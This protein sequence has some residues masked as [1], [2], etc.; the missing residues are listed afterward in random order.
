VPNRPFRAA[1]LVVLG[2]LVGTALADGP[3]SR[4]VLD[5][6]A[7]W[8]SH[9]EFGIDRID[10]GALKATGEEVLGERNLRLL[11]RKVKG[12]LKHL[13]PEA[14]AEFPEDWRDC[15]YYH[16][17]ISQFT[18]TDRQA[19]HC[20][21]P[22]APADWMKPDF[23]DSGWPR[24][25]LPFMVGNYY[26]SSL[27]HGDLEMQW[28]GV[29][30]ACYRT[31]FE[32]ADPAVPY[33][34]ELSYRGG[35]RVFVNGAEIA[36][37]DLP[38]GE[39]GPDAH[40]DV[41][42]ADA[43]LRRRREA[44]V[45]P[46]KGSHHDRALSR[47]G[48][49]FAQELP[50]RFEDAFTDLDPKRRA[51]PGQELYWHDGS[52]WPYGGWTRI[53]RAGFERLTKLRSRRTGPVRIP[54]RLL[55][56]G[57]NLLAIEVRASH[58]HPVVA[59]GRKGDWGCGLTQGA[60][61]YWSH[62]RLLELTLS[63]G[64]LEAPSALERPGGWRVWVGDM[65][66]RLYS[67]EWGPA[68]RARAVVR[69][70]GGPNGSYSALVAASSDRE[71][72]GLTA[73]CGDLRSNG[74]D[75]IP[76]SALTV[77][78]MVGEPADRLVKL[79]QVR[80]FPDQLRDPLCPPAELA[81]RRHGGIDLH[82]PR[83]PRPERLAKIAGMRF[84][85]HIGASARADVPAGTCRPLWLRLQVPADARPGTYRG[86]LAV[87][88]EG[89]APVRLPVEAE[90]VGWRV[91]DPQA[92]QTHVCLEESP[93]GVAAHYKVALWSDEHFRLIETSLKQLG[94]VG[95][96][97]VV[98][99]VIRRM[100]FGNGDDTSIIRWIRKRDGTWAFDYGPFDRY[101]DLAVKHL[102]K[103]RILC[104]AIM[105]GGGMY[106]AV[107][108][109]HAVAYLDE[110]DG[111]VGLLDLSRGTPH[112][113]RVWTSFAVQL[114][115]H[116]KE[117]G[118][119]DRLMW[120]YA[121]DGLSDSQLPTLLADCVPE[122]G[123]VQGAHR[124]GLGISP[125]QV[126]WACSRVYGA[127][128]NETSLLGW[129]KRTLDVLNPRSGSTVISTN[130]HSPP[131]SFRLMVDRA[132]VSGQNG[133]GRLGADFW[134][135]TY[136]KQ[137]GVSGYFAVG[138]PCTQLLWPG[139]DGAHASARFEALLEGVQE[140]EARIFLE[141]AIDRN[142]LPE[143]VARKAR[144]ALY[145]HNRETLYIP[146]GSMVIQ[147]HEYAS[148][149]QERSR[150]LYRVAA[151]AARAT[152]LD[153]DRLRLSAR[154]PPGARRRRAGGIEPIR[155]P[156]RGRRRVHVTLR[157]WTGRPRAWRIEP[158]QPW[159]VPEKASGD[160]LGCLAVPI[161]LDADGLET[162]KAVKGAFDV[163]DVASGRRH[164]VSVHAEA[165]K[166]FEFKPP[167]CWGGPP[168]IVFNVTPGQ[169]RERKFPLA[170]LSGAPLRWE[171]SSSVPWVTARPASGT[172]AAGRRIFITIASRPPGRADAR[173][174]SNLRVGEAGADRRREVKVVTYVQ[175]PY[176]EPAAPS[177]PSVDLASVSKELLADHH[178]EP[179]SFLGDA[180]TGPAFGKVMH[181][182][183]LK[184]N[185]PPTT[186]NASARHQTVYNIGGGGFR[187]FS[188]RVRVNPQMARLRKD[189]RSTSRVVFEVWVDGR[190]RAQS[191]IMTAR[192]AAR[193]IVADGL[194]G[195]RELK[196]VTRFDTPDITNKWA[197]WYNWLECSWHEP[198]LY[199][200][201]AGR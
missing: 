121:W 62:C 83:P 186:L 88:A 35:V 161:A 165:G 43:Y 46:K 122:V 103:P 22:P 1:S 55:R 112:Y 9:V 3:E 63:A 176:R 159:I 33:V 53:N 106:G 151:E 74:G 123:W 130:G 104:V 156:A 7:Y 196:L 117:R 71:L 84:F 75:V 4:L 21:T 116:L 119:A 97:M 42:P 125:G 81:L 85:D 39:L 115:A 52:H 139:P 193:L 178:A 128:I 184:I 149:W 72:K 69:F 78:C 152:P 65:H 181:H 58:F 28:L 90:V 174:E 94:R 107:R 135:D 142:L 183:R 100:E 153:V 61:L 192:D 32:V 137:T 5:E 141:Q 190:I 37:R 177:G 18:S 146:G 143:D 60:N 163:V 68:G 179:G 155:V 126:Y 167:Q 124:P 127:Q 49:D 198:R 56:K 136:H 195:A 14:R 99:P 118:L 77:A 173:I 98:L 20:A 40:A 54:A 47:V 89:L 134:A 2:A 144:R 57:D 6:S 38:G 109:R 64:S 168:R 96:D 102:G 29:R 191:G 12:Y 189:V 172:L 87:S 91:P 170:N 182:G 187:T 169:E 79:G 133:I 108:H 194:T 150:R 16:L 180:K 92:F 199:K 185:H 59:T 138:M 44:P 166:V 15:P 129:K 95:N 31:R 171:A 114:Y 101:L 27:M 93:Y 30:A 73:S 160:L 111:R 66:R 41:Y 36:R 162:D 8:R 164:S 50:G 17:Y 34:L 154:I 23:D 188:A 147:V 51:G 80:S 67:P 200:S 13:S 120:G 76:A 10:S 131:F 86:T 45:D 110:A 24:Q 201:K 157:N 11:E 19:V 82:A 132:L 148:G 48:V 158:K 140:A 175:T 145:D 197:T 25:R 26:R 70:V 105:H 113:K